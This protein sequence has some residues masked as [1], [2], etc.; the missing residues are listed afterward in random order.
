MIKIYFSK[1]QKSLH[2]EDSKN[3]KYLNI[4]L[5]GDDLPCITT[6]TTEIKTR[7]NNKTQKQ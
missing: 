7:R 2:C 1:I 6:G 3:I 4:L 5:L